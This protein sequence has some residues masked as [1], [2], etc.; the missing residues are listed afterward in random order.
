MPNIELMHRAYFFKYIEICFT[1][2]FTGS[3]WICRMSVTAEFRTAN[4]S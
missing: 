1:S 2:V 4:K 3:I